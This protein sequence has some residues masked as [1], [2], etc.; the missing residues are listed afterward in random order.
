LLA[1]LLVSWRAPAA[2]FDLKDSGWE[3]C[4]GLLGVLA[5]AIGQGRVL[6]PRA[7]A[8]GELRP[9]DGLLVVHP[10]RALNP[11]ELSAFLKAGGRVAVLDDFGAGGEML[12]RFR[13]ERI[14]PPARPARSL[15]NNP[16]LAVAEP[17]ADT[18][19][20]H[21]LGVHPVVANVAQV[22]TNHP[23]GLTHP[24]LSPVLV[25]RARGEPDVVVGVAGQVGKGRLIA[26]SDGSVVINQMLRYPGNREL[27]AGIARYLVDDDQ[28]GARG[29]RL[30]VVT[31]DVV[32]EGAFGNQSS[33]AKSIGA[34]A[35]ELSTLL[36]KLHETGLGPTSATVVGGLAAIATLAWLAAAG[37]RAYRRAA[38]RFAR[39]VPL[40]AQGGIAGRAAVLAAPSTHR[41][42]AILELKSALEEAMAVRLGLELPVAA[43]ALLERAESAGALDETRRKA[44]KRLLLMMGIV[45]TSVTAGRP[46]RIRERDVREAADSVKD[47]LDAI[48]RPGGEPPREPRS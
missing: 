28:W 11:D 43:Q 37:A 32:E 44:L 12:A 5:S 21:Q 46:I 34:A 24:N 19:A 39:G 36:G 35:R 26:V 29:G 30:F 8:W 2:P 25:V 9:E 16:A 6:T 38:P 13:I 33:I 15:R 7:L 27:A 31:G 42:L 1:A 3:G 20:G 14:A 23:T 22:V 40:V 41:A 10:V 48:E 45:E 4:S 17:I 18:T 47:L